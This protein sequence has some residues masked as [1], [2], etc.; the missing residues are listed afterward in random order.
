MT[1]LLLEAIRIGSH[2]DLGPVV[3]CNIWFNNNLSSTCLFAGEYLF[4]CWR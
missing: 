1:C 3:Y 4:V 2:L